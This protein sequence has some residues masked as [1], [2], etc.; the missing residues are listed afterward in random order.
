MLPWPSAYLP[1]L[2]TLSLIR[3]WKKVKTKY[4]ERT[5]SFDKT[6]YERKWMGLCEGQSQS[7][8]RVLC[9]RLR[10]LF[11]HGKVKR[12]FRGSR[13][14]DP[15][16]LLNSFGAPKS[17]D[18]TRCVNVVDNLGFPQ[19]CVDK[20]NVFTTPLLIRQWSKNSFC[21]VLLNIELANVSCSSWHEWIWESR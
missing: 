12:K 18:T 11:T 21:Y 8:Q 3:I 6:K 13:L 10:E 5:L 17:G 15:L 2:R 20:L 4:E 16:T 14:R 1:I 9:T 7:I 19:V